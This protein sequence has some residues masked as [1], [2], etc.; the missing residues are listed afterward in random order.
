MH[1]S[2]EIFTGRGEKKRAAGTGKM[3]IKRRLCFNM[4]I[5]DEN[6]KK[7]MNTYRKFL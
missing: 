6:R 5:K 1:V 4:D 3:L 7:G 2:T